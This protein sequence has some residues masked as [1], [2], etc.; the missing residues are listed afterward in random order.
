MPGVVS[1]SIAAERGSTEPP[2]TAS[3]EEAASHFAAALTTRL[4]ITAGAIGD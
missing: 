3:V 2:S 1:T 4:G